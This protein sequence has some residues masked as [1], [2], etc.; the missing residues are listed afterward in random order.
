MESSKN[1]L[2]TE[3]QIDIIAL[4]S[5]VWYHKKSI[6]KTVVIFGVIG[7]IVALSTPNKFTASSLFTP[8]YSGQ[9]GG[10]SGLKG[11]A[12]L[13]GI[14]VGSMEGTK[15]VSPMLY[16][17]ITE[18]ATF[19]K[20]LLTAPIENIE[21]VQTLKD[22]FV[23]KESES[24]FLGTLKGYTIGLPGKVIGWF[25]SDASETRLKVVQGIEA[26]SKDDYGYFKAIDGILTLSINDKDGFIEM[27]AVSENPKLA[28]QVA[29]N[30]EVILQNQIIAIK[31]KS[32]LELLRYL[33]GQ[34]EAK[35]ALLNK[36]QERLST[37]KDRNLNIATN[38]FSIQQT[39][40]ESELRTAG[41]VFDNVVTQLEQVKLQVTK[42]TPVFSILKPVVFP[43]EKSEPK[44]SL[45]VVVWLFLGAVLSIGFILA[46]EPVQNLLKEIKTASI[47]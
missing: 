32:S 30:G 6:L 11:L 12:S 31:T 18:G 34:Y 28:A 37:F 13:A 16:G 45:I 8:N 36:A 25:K 10:S 26:I 23:Q 29:K 4:L 3:D 22:Y 27:I 14:N 42:D 9:S 41:V 19:K 39:R 43:N 17:K 38:S 15:E 47:S 44:R 2:Q 40:L 21:G 46:K 20:A 24:S 33:E 1:N 5:K 35:K 7:I